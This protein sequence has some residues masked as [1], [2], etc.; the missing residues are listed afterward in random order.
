MKK[1]IM[2]VVAAA[3]ILTTSA[4]ADYV[5]IQNVDS[6]QF[7]YVLVDRQCKSATELKNQFN[8]VDNYGRYNDA[9]VVKDNFIDMSPDS[10]S[11]R[12]G[13]LEI[14]KNVKGGRMTFFTTKTFEKCSKLL[15]I[16]NNR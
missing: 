14:T 12:V 6:S 2:T 1:I 10:V 7:N 9:Q 3:A 15:S 11:E 8:L 5:T 16:L 4:N 13:V